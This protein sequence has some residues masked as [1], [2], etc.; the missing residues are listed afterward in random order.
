MLFLLDEDHQ[1]SKSQPEGQMSSGKVTVQETQPIS[2]LS[3]IYLFS[4][5]PCQV[6]LKLYDEVCAH[7]SLH[8]FTW[9]TENLKD[10]FFFFF[11]FFD[12]ERKDMVF[13]CWRWRAGT[14]PGGLDHK[15]VG[16]NVWRQTGYYQAVT[17][18]H[19]VKESTYLTKWRLMPQS[20]CF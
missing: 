7:A 12:Q 17:S 20:T 6:D 8:V 4:S 16:K 10:K 14:R 18:C 2:C 1:W 15:S 3:S 19:S 5:N 11:F 9:A 13:T